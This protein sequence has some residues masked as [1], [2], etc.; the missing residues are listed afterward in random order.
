MIEDYKLVV[1]PGSA[2][3]EAVGALMEKALEQL[4]IQIAD[5]YGCHCLRNR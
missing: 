1:N 5:E 3:G 2:I 4:L